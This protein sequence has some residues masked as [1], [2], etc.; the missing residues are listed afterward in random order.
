[1]E[2]FDSHTHTHTLTW[3]ALRAEMELQANPSRGNSL[4]KM[5]NSEHI[6]IFSTT[7]MTLNYQPSLTMAIPI[8][9]FANILYRKY[10]SFSLV[11]CTDK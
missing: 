1:M 5:S 6:E 7:C 8:I 4:W 3:Q 2:Q 11:L 9:P 10:F